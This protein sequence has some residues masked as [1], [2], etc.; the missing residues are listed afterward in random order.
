MD[1][2]LRKTTWAQAYDRILGKATCKYELL[3]DE[4]GRPFVWIT[5]LQTPNR[6]P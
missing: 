5:S 4:S 1:F 6:K 2:P 3:I